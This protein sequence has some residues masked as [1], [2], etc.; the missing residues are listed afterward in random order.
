MTVKACVGNA[1]LKYVV[2]PTPS[3]VVLM[4][5]PTFR[6]LVSFEISIN[7]PDFISKLIGLKKKLNITKICG[8]TR[9]DSLSIF[10]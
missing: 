8:N 2:L 6:S 4:L 5:F 1:V 9:R 3:C 7:L 10:S